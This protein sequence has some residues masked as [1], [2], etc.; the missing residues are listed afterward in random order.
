MTAQQGDAA[1]GCALIG[2]I[3]LLVGVLV[4]LIVEAWPIL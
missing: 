3:G 4:M 2:L 1:L